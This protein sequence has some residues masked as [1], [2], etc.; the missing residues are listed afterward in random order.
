MAKLDES[1]ES[2]VIQVLEKAVVPQDKSKPQRSM[3]VLIA[4][5]ATGFLAILYAF[6]AEAL[7]KAKEDEEQEAQ[8]EALKAN[9]R[10]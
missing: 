8:I 3:I 9:L 1:K 7:N 5:L 6:I 10:W 4:A 2:T